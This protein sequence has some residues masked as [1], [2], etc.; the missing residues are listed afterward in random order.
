MPKV[1]W[2]DVPQTSSFRTVIGVVPPTEE[3]A[4]TY[5]N[6]LKSNLY[7]ITRACRRLHLKGRYSLQ[8]VRSPR[9]EVRTAFENL[10]DAEVFGAVV[11]LA[12]PLPVVSSFLL[13]NENSAQLE[14]VGGPPDRGDLA[15]GHANV[16]PHSR[17][18]TPF[19]KK[20][21]R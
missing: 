12:S 9:L 17:G 10:T 3:A 8:V 6:D 14:K 13:D 21:G 20:L 5:S 19:G 16:T 11:G 18:R 15:A 2:L 4:A 1:H 7:L